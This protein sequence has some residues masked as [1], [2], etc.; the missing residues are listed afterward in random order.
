ML[1]L[2]KNHIHASLLLHT[3][4]ALTPKAALDALTMELKT[5]S[6]SQFL[7][8]NSRSSHS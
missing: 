2:I 6:A 4:T 7:G 5:T 8:G 3:E 1:G